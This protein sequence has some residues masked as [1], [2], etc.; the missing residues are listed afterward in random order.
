MKAKDI[1]I[2]KTYRHRTSSVGYAQPVSLIPPRSGVNKSAAT[3][4]KCG[5]SADPRFLVFMFK[6]FKPSDLVEIK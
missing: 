5:W 2:G 1:V 3:L 6:Y 4:V